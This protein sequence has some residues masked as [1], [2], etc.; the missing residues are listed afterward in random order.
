MN[1]LLILSYWI[2]AYAEPF[3]GWGLY[4]L[5]ALVLFLWLVALVFGLFFKRFSSEPSTRR[6]LKKLSSLLGTEGVLLALTL[7][8]TQTQTPYLGSRWWWL[9][10]LV[11]AAIWLWF[12]LVYAVKVAPQEKA[13]RFQEQQRLK[14]LS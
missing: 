8:F 5:V 2:E 7:F 9:L 12:I 3:S 11:L 1:N 6:I 4:S 13:K 14:Y 10:W